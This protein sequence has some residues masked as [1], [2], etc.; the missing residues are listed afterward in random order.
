MPT[1]QPVFEP[2]YRRPIAP[3]GADTA[4][5]VEE[6]VDVIGWFGI[7]VEVIVDGIIDEGSHHI[8]YGTAAARQ[9]YGSNSRQA[10]LTMAR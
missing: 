3:I 10:G 1:T 9:V 8:V 5:V 6:K 7:R 4:G 2:R